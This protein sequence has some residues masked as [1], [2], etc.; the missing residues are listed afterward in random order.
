VIVADTSVLLAAA[1]PRDAS[2]GTCRRFLGEARGPLVVPMPVAFEAAEL[3]GS[4]VSQ[5]AASAFLSDCASGS[6]L[7]V[8]VLSDD[9]SRV[10][11]LVED[12]ADLRLGA[13]DAAIVATAE[14]LGVTTIATLDRRHFS[15]VRPAHADAFTL[16]P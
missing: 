15:V 16:V 7:A 10:A 5:A 14:R 4:R 1:D 6:F 2:H 11:E 3:I 9:L 8:A 13:V 12:Y